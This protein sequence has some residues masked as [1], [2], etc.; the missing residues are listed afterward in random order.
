MNGVPL[1]FGTI[2]APVRQPTPPRQEQQYEKGHL[3]DTDSPEGYL[4]NVPGWE[5]PTCPTCSL[6]MRPRAAKKGGHF[7]GC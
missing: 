6:V 3:R 1:I 5:R 7:W 2:S 4:Y